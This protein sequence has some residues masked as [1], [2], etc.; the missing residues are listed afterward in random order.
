MNFLKKVFSLKLFI[1]LLSVTASAYWVFYFIDSENKLDKHLYSENT[2]ED[3]RLNKFHNYEGVQASWNIQH[4]YAQYLDKA[5]KV[6]SK[7]HGTRYFE[8]D[9]FNSNLLN[10]DSSKYLETSLNSKINKEFILGLN[11]RFNLK[12][13]TEFESKA[14]QYFVGHYVILNGDNRYIGYVDR[15]TSEYITVIAPLNM[16]DVITSIELPYTRKDQSEFSVLLDSERMGLVRGGVVNQFNDKNKTYIYIRTFNTKDSI[17]LIK[18]DIQAKI[19]NKIFQIKNLI[20]LGMQDF[21]LEIEGVNKYKP[22]FDSRENIIT[23]QISSNIEQRKM[24]LE[25]ENIINDK[26]LFGL[27]RNYNVSVK[28]DSFI[29]NNATVYFQQENNPLELVQHKQNVLSFD[30]LNAVTNKL[31]DNEDH[32]KIV[33]KLNDRKFSSLTNEELAIIKKIYDD[34]YSKINISPFKI[35]LKGGNVHVYY[36]YNNNY[37]A[38]KFVFDKKIKTNLNFDIWEIYPGS[39]LNLYY[40]KKNPAPTEMMIHV[41]GHDARDDYYSAFERIKPEYVSFAKPERF[42]PWLLNWHWNF[43][44]NMIENYAPVVDLDEFSLWKRE[45]AKENNLKSDDVLLTKSLPFSVELG[46]S[47]DIYT[48]YTV[49]VDYQISNPYE[50]LPLLGKAS[51]F[52]ITTNSSITTLPVSIPW[53]EKSWIFPLVVKG[54]KDINFDVKKMSDY[55]NSA[56]IKIDSLS[57][58]KENVSQKKIIEMFLDYKS[59]R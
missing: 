42:T 22:Y 58:E 7:D 20:S 14:R 8:N 19:N 16:G 25:I 6:I 44:K 38:N 59:M 40:R 51:R 36:Q 1:L 41:L 53:S 29:K 9:S 46:S 17:K 21:I 10:V 27:Q 57:I 48:L 33:E 15:V 37:R 23:L 49:K 45:Q 43:F 28:N 26:F 35:W 55:L 5:T 32:I 47:D 39:I 12:I 30:L 13:N 52:F 24:T 18:G 56:S 31:K 54:K 34:F 50:M 2:F 3:V 4:E 11:H